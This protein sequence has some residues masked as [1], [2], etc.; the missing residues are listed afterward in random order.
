MGYTY[1]LIS[2]CTVTLFKIGLYFFSSNLSV[3]FFLFFVV[4]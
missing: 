3:V 1:Y 4:I 2:L